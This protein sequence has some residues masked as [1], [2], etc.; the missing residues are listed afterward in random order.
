[1][2]S[3]YHI[4]S[5]CVHVVLNPPF[6][7][8]SISGNHDLWIRKTSD[9]YGQENSI[10]KFHAVV[11]LC[12]AIGVYIRP[13][14]VQCC[15][16][17]SA[18]V[19]P[20]YSWYAQPEDDPNNSLYIAR[21]TEDAEFSKR[22][23]MD[24]HMCKWPS[25]QRTVSQHFA[26]LSEKFV[27]RNYDAPV[28]SF[29]HFLPRLELIPASDEEIKHV[30]EERKRLNLP[31]LDNPRA[32]GAQVQFN[33]TRFAGSKRVEEQI[34]RLGSKVHVHGHQHRNRDRVID[35]VRY[36][37]FC[38]GYPRERSIGVI[39]GLSEGNGPRQIWPTE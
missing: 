21:D 16:N 11:A 25:L 39:W 17:T 35:G 19:V 24:N 8:T 7:F 26:E 31:L 33:F 4:L 34:R 28:I 1:M 15:N 3:W 22:V 13:V 38:L 18:W 37:S 32:Q 6:V 30:E 23:W 9:A 14:K 20:I 27:N 5:T 36:V 2:T 10:S 29:S 12:D